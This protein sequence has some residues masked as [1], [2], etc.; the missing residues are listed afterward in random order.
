MA[1]QT[2]GLDYQKVTGAS[3]DFPLP[4]CEVLWENILTRVSSVD[5]RR[6]NKQQGKYLFSPCSYSVIKIVISL[7]QW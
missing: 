7:L 4:V 1:Y 5:I 6:S 3:S 2:A